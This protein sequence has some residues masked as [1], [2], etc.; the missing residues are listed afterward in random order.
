MTPPAPA[1]APATAPAPAA[2]DNLIGDAL[3][4]AVAAYV[5][6]NPASLAAHRRAAEVLPGGN[7][8][9]VLHYDPFPLTMVGGEGCR[10]TDADGHVYIDFLGEFTAGLY[11]HSDPAIARAIAAAVAGGL[12]LG[13]QTPREG[14][15]ARL[16][17][18]RFPSMERLRF[19]NSGT[20]ANLMAI[21]AAR[22]ETGRA[23][24]MVFAG[25][26][27]GGV[28][29]FPAGSHAVN[30]PHE[31]VIASYNDIAATRALIRD[32]AA[33]LAAVLVEPMMGAAGCLPATPDFLAMLRAETAA[34]G[35]LLIL[36]EVMTSRL[37]PGGRQ[38]L[39]GIAPD[40]TT[41]G[42]YVGG[43]MSVG[44]FGGR[45]G[46]MDRFDPRRPDALPHAG[47]FNNNAITMA[48]GI[49]GLRD[50]YTAAAALALNAR[51]EAL[52]EALN[53]LFREGGVA[54]CAT[55]LGS[56]M[57]L[58]PVAVPP[59]R[60]ADLAGVDRRLRDLVFLDLLE[61]GFY[62]ARR[63]LLALSL[64]VGEAE[65]AALLAAV[66]RR[67]PRWRGL[68]PAAAPG[69]PRGA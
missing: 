36:D 38:A 16:I 61:D 1:P 56:L 29:T 66:R 46:V 64:P 49:V 18:D 31:F 21:A 2:G 8:R 48:A 58:H 15:L 63:G 40:L 35:A 59:V 17:R 3:A 54:I 47:T 26:Y 65:T 34:A 13:S 24:V 57:T 32:H 52:R 12:N 39:L 51:G 43:G 55:G 22:A 53:A 68:A 27:H 4:A 23:R 9:S 50:V 25:A 33:G 14:E 20:E 11:G 10:L 45:A 6:R 19:T 60:P 44:A 67:L 30:V 5:A 42:K 62:L 7:T 37:S 69:G 28:L 41:L